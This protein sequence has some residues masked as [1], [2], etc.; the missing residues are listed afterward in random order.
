MNPIYLDHNATTPLDPA[1]L[2][3][4]LP[5]LKGE[6]GN[7]SSFHAPGRAARA[8]V[9]QA[10]ERV[11]RLLGAEPREIVFTSGGTEA[12]N[13]AL[14]GVI[15]L[16]RVPGGEPAHV[17]T[18]AIEHPA[19][20]NTCQALEKQ[21][22]RVTYLPVDR[23]GRLD[24]QGVERALTG[25]T[26]LVSIMLA[27]NE[28]GSVQP[29]AEAARHARARGVPVHT[30]AV[31][32]AGRLATDVNALGVDLLSISGHKIYGPKGT[33]A[34]YIRRGT[35]VAPLIQGGHQERRR[36]GGTENVP[37]IVGLGKAAEL[38]LERLAQGTGHE[39]ALRDRLEQGLR[40]R[41]PHVAIN[42]HPTERLPNTLNA[43]FRFVEGEAL[44]MN[45]DLE[46]VC[47]STGS[48]C[49]SGDLEPSHVLTAMGIP[50]EE[51]HGTLRFSLGKGTTAEEID[52]TI[53]IV[54]RVVERVRAMS[55]IYADFMK[56]QKAGA[57]TGA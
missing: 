9:E 47:V 8:A 25:S 44:L 17:I 43:G 32:A 2:E 41:V 38:A 26:A 19:V 40:A 13:Q 48:A 12:D 24:P 14:R 4:M 45:L 50:V 42:G 46:G 51:A 1:V 39:A 11:A 22:V 57:A 53:E 49:S 18:T 52:R 54:A 3:A 23:Y 27:N 37:G 34:L 5:Y 10:R 6:Y 29:V 31:Q 56:R 33:G 16:A 20:L 28:V 30:D 55:P 36:R 7:A 15:E 21:G 35:R